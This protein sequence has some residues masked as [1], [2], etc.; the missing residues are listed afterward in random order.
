MG[1]PNLEVR[2]TISHLDLSCLKDLSQAGFL[3]GG[4]GFFGVN[5]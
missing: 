5:I 1:G 2:G 4:D 3:K